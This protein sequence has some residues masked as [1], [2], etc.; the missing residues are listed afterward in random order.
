VQGDSG[1]RVPL[2]L[3]CA[4]GV[5]LR[6]LFLL[7]AGELEF[8]ADESTYVYHAVTWNHF[9]VYIDSHRFLWPPG[10]AFFLARWLDALGLR[11]LFF[12]KLC[13]V[14]A[15]ASVGL[16]VMLLARR[17]FGDRAAFLAGTLWCVYLPL[18]GYTHYLR[19]ETLFLA[20]LL[21]ALY[22]LQAALQ[23]E[24]RAR[25]GR[26][27]LAGALLALALHVKEAAVLLPL[28][29]ALLLALRAPA[30][31]EGL[32]RASLF[33]LALAV[34]VAPWTLRNAEVYGRFTFLGSSLGENVHVGLNE[35]YKNYDIQAFTRRY[36][37]ELVPGDHTRRW[38]V[39]AE[40]G[41]G[42][43]RAVEIHNLVDRQAEQVRRALAYAAERPGW[44]LRS[45]L[46]KLAD[47]VVPYSFF[48]RHQG[49]DGYAGSPLG[50]GGVR[51]ALLAWALVLPVAV[52]LLAVPGYVAALRDPPSRWLFGAV[53]LYFAAT[54]LVNSMSRVR[55]PMEPLGLALAGGALAA[56]PVRAL[57]D[58]RVAAPVGALWAVL[59]FLWWVDWPELV[60]VV[61]YAWNPRV[62]S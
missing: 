19:T 26:L 3:L 27:L 4:S 20:L 42:W 52:M 1:A 62:P 31:V 25:D 23:E 14:L 48:V 9:G 60:Q 34:V 15:S 8:K 36:F 51:H 47:L 32:R 28:L 53:L 11:G 16:S 50:A 49:L 57:R 59:L 12:A 45:R 24:G 33:L 18:I 7:L 54:G 58:P 5:A 6:L 56:G 22:Q 41:S 40:P 43:Q 39:E 37:A 35:S 55:V 46:K 38:F 30:P 17:A 13:Q 21:P 29:L 2:L 44:L 10:Y 61:D